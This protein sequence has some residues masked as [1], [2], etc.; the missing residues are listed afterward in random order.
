MTRRMLSAMVVR[1][2]PPSPPHSTNSDG[3][4]EDPHEAMYQSMYEGH[5]SFGGIG[6]ASNTSFNG[7]S[8]QPMYAPTSDYSHNVSLHHQRVPNSF[9]IRTPPADDD[10]N[11]GS[12]VSRSGSIETTASWPSPLRRATSSRKKVLTLPKRQRKAKRRSRSEIRPSLPHPLSILT[13][14]ITHIPIKD[15]ELL[16]NRSTEQR[17][18]EVMQKNGKIPRPMNS[19]MLYR[20]AYADRSK[21]WLTQNNHQIVSEVAGESWAMETQEIR[22]KYQALANL[23]KSN[24]MKAH[25]AYKFTPSKDNKKKRAGLNNER[26]SVGADVMSRSGRSPAPRY[27][28]TFS[29]PEIDN[30]SWESISNHSTP[31]NGPMDHGLPTTDGYFSSSWPTSHPSRTLSGMTLT[32]EPSQYA[33]PGPNPGL[34]GYVEDVRLRRGDMDEMQ[35]ASS[36][37][38]AGLPGAAHHD[39]LGNHA[40]MPT[41]EIGQLDPQLL[42]YHGNASLN[43]ED[44]SQLYG[45]PHYL[46]Q[47]SVNNSYV[48]VSNSMADSPVTYTGTSSFPPAPQPLADGREAWA[49]SQGGSLDAAGGDF[50]AYINHHP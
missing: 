48:L 1:G 19:F 37:T 33:Q 21:A 4:S 12:L 27:T 31:F 11:S 40:Q 3:G 5:G 46:W 2:G 15:M 50:D 26:C 16:V 45:S 13:K 14:D 29:S 35:Y 6:Q 39:L 7:Q 49:A 42:E 20:S 28:S 43:P 38:L 23:E 34:M 30:H 44:G 32:S 10:F 25:P 41:T 18:L 22:S 9:N 47:E 24:H 36:T 8:S 17:K